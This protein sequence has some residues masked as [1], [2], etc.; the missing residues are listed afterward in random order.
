MALARPGHSLAICGAAK[1]IYD[2]TQLP[3]YDVSVW[4]TFVSDY[5]FN[6]IH[7][8]SLVLRTSL[9]GDIAFPSEHGEK[10]VTASRMMGY[11]LAC[12]T[13]DPKDRVYSL[14]AILQKQ[15]IVIP[16]PDYN[17]SL[18][19][20]YWET[21]ATIIKHEESLDVLL[22]ISGIGPG[23]PD[24]PS[25]VPDFRE[26]YT[27]RN[28]H[29]YGFSATFD[30]SAQFVILD[31]DKILHT[32]ASVIDVIL[33]CSANTT[34]QPGPSTTRVEDSLL[35][36]LELGCQQTIKAL[37]DWTWL[38]F[39]TGYKSRYDE[40]NRLVAFRETLLYGFISESHMH[41]RQIFMPWV[42]LIM[43]T[44]PN[45]CNTVN[46][47]EVTDNAKLN[48]LLQRARENPELRAHFFENPDSHELMETDEWKILCAAKTLPGFS[49]VHHHVWMM[50]RDCTFF[51]TKS[52]YVGTGPYSI[53][54]GG[55]IA[56]I[57]GL[58]MPMVLRPAEEVGHYRVVAPAYVQGMMQG[59]IWGEWK[60]KVEA[61]MLI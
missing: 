21:T 18:G 7:M 49:D 33:D 29:G 31:D 22:L 11:M 52:G 47:E 46:G 26:A 44:N 60:E 12:D 14:Y 57:P 23:L 34:W 3:L 16:E 45:W 59:E 1:T 13:T 51:V 61:V 4:L 56:L 38:P 2:S 20:I 28:A 25:W 24:V 39:K 35:M 6:A 50:S 17:K 58:Q 53:Q 27:L 54:E 10:A 42:E 48:A 9:R 37:R 55:V 30:S 5:P 40:S 15:G 36:N 32:S 19:Q 43:C 41:T 8:G